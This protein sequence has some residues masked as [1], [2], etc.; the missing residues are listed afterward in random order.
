MGFRLRQWSCQIG[1]KLLEQTTRESFT[2]ASSRSTM[3]TTDH[4]EPVRMMLV[5]PS[6]PAL[7][8]QGTL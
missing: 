1:R 2:T 6:R 3:A 7:K 4:S 8:E 5:S